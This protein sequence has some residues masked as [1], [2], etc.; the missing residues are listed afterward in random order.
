MRHP[1]KRRITR[2]PLNTRVRYTSQDDSYTQEMIKRLHKTLGISE[3][4]SQSTTKEER[5]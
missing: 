5:D 2:K 4:K 1:G 3:S